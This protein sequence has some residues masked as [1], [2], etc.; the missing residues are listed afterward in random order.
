MDLAWAA[1][2]L[3]LTRGGAVTVAELTATATPAVILPYPYHADRQQERNAAPLVEAG[4]ARVVTDRK[5]PVAT[6]N[7]L[8]T[9]LLEL[10]RDPARLEAM[11]QAATGQARTDAAQAVAEWLI[12]AQ[13]RE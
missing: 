8:R 10:L 1:A 12:Q 5:D 9:E 3:A 13:P 6:A 4:C 2:D 11:Q 7:A